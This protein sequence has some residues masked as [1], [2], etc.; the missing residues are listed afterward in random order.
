[1]YGFKFLALKMNEEGRFWVLGFVLIWQVNL[2]MRLA[3]APQASI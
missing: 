1:M 2:K 3:L